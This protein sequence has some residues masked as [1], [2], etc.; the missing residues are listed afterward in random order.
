MFSHRHILSPFI[1]SQLPE[2]ILYD[3]ENSTGLDY[4]RFVRLIEFY[5]EYLEQEYEPTLEYY[6]SVLITEVKDTQILNADANKESLY[7][8]LLKLQSL[9]DIDQTTFSM[10]KMFNSEYGQNIPASVLTDRVTL[11]KN[12]RDFY[13]SKGSEKSFEF[14]FRILFNETIE[15]E[16][17]KDS[18]LTASGSSWR[19]IRSIRII[20]SYD[21]DPIDN[22]SGNV[23]DSDDIIGLSGYTMAG[24]QSNAIVTIT[25]IRSERDFGINFLEIFIDV[26]SMVGEF[27]PG[28]LV[29]FLQEDGSIFGLANSDFN[30]EG[31]II[32][33]IESVSVERSGFGYEEGDLLSVSKQTF[34]DNIETNVDGEGAIVKVVKTEKGIIDGVN[35]I[36]AGSGYVDTDTINLVKNYWTAYSITLDTG[37]TYDDV[38]GMTV[39]GADTHSTATI[40]FID[41]RRGRIWIDN[42]SGEDAFSTDEKAGKWAGG[43]LIYTVN[44][45]IS[46]RIVRETSAEGFGEEIDIVS[47]GGSGELTQIRIVEGGKNYKFKPLAYVNTSTGTGGSVELISD[48]V[49]AIR[50]A[51]VYNP[52][53]NYDKD[54]ED[55][56]FVPTIGGL[57]NAILNVVVGSTKQY[58]GTSVGSSNLSDLS[59][60][61]DG[62]YYQTYSYVIKT[63]ISITE[64][65]DVVKK[66][67]HPVGTQ[68][69]SAIDVK[70]KTELPLVDIKA[71][72][73]LLLKEKHVSIEKKSKDFLLSKIRIFDE[74][75]RSSILSDVTNPEGILINTI[76]KEKSAIDLELSPI[77]NFS[78][79]VLS[80]INLS[81]DIKWFREIERPE[82]NI[83]LTNANIVDSILI[84][85]PNKLSVAENFVVKV[86]NLP[87]IIVTDT[88][89]KI[90]IDTVI[91]ELF[92]PFISDSSVKSENFENLLLLALKNISINENFNISVPNLPVKI[93]FS[94]EVKNGFQHIISN[95]LSSKIYS[96]LKNGSIDNILSSIIKNISVN[97]NFNVFSPNIPVDITTNTN[98]FITAD[99]VVSNIIISKTKL[100]FE[101]VKV[102]DN[103]FSYKPKILSVSENFIVFSPNIPVYIESEIDY[104]MDISS[105][106]NY[107][108]E[109][110]TKGKLR[111]S[112]NYNAINLWYNGGTLSLEV[113]TIPVPMG[114]SRDTHIDYRNI[115]KEGYQR[116]PMITDGDE[117]A[118][119]PFFNHPLS[120]R[121]FASTNFSFTIRENDLDSSRIHL[122]V[123]KELTFFKNVD[124]FRM[125]DNIDTSWARVYP[126]LR[127]ADVG[128]TEWNSDISYY[129]IARKFESS[130]FEYKSTFTNKLINGLVDLDSY[131][132]FSKE[133]NY[134]NF[135][136]STDSFIIRYPKGNKVKM[137]FD[138]FTLGIDK[139]PYIPIKNI[140]DYDIK[141]KD[142]EIEMFLK[143]K[144]IKNTL[145]V[146]RYLQ[147]VS[148]RRKLSMQQLLVLQKNSINIAIMNDFPKRFTKG[149]NS[150]NNFLSFIDRR[151]GRF[152]ID[153]VKDS[154]IEK[155]VSIGDGGTNDKNVTLNAE[156]LK[157]LLFYQHDG[158]L[159]RIRTDDEEVISLLSYFGYYIDGIDLVDDRFF[160]N[161]NNVKQQRLISYTGE[162][163]LKFSTFLG[164]QADFVN[165]DGGDRKNT[166]ALNFKN[167]TAEEW[168]N[169]HGKVYMP[170][171]YLRMIRN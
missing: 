129:Y 34:V 71:A 149:I 19:E 69:F 8:Q 125:Q 99:T 137:P 6:K 54:K 165:T 27:I 80:K 159:D 166:S 40:R 41:E 85:V 153:Y 102:V 113:D 169:K 35:I 61:H 132:S 117:V 163:V 145:V 130:K 107:S 50:V 95:I 103:I 60:I 53:I 70:L 4:S 141:I 23:T 158:T 66:L 42:V 73:S 118:L 79:D 15:I 3:Y 29:N 157:D 112:I 108:L 98:A 146:P 142:T 37:V 138:A 47:V 156:S 18:I 167:M 104:N 84:Y 133:I 44:N 83:A 9:R 154:T 26:A 140:I 48:S 91:T 119:I 16:Y 111:S 122:N 65:R 114:L 139:Y 1:K 55:L 22:P 58:A 39:I 89:A 31:K 168:N 49:G 20:P 13:Q 77:I 134:L 36:D 147:Y 78:S 81:S 97:N 136:I 101:N 162:D 43:E 152:W 135:N 68:M 56:Y 14:L 75:Y 88:Q 131:V 10:M 144:H 155:F 63:A 116:Y 171:A 57:N 151:N 46:F 123:D 105:I 87:V 161:N 32:S 17:P 90:K 30:I 106:T 76:S 82:L 25:S 33:G 164:N 120:I 150:I 11:L 45:E 24:S 2:S 21:L 121:A 126:A 72:N 128:G 12:I 74:Y 124:S 62:Y 148:V 127:S 67:V 92:N 170:D 160:I 38:I 59:K 7:K 115:I 96:S 52:G 64:W 51:E 5:Y 100:L 109:L 86:P 143:E 93:I 94:A 110:K 28:E